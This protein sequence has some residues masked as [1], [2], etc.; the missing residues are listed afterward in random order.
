MSLETWKDEFYPVEALAVLKK[1]AVEHSLRK[2]RGLRA[3]NRAKHGVVL[4]ACG[5]VRGD[6]G[7][8]LVIASS[9]CALCMWYS[10]SVGY[11]RRCPIVKCNG[12]GCDGD[13]S[14]YV[15]FLG[16]GDPEPMIAL[17]EKTLAWEKARKK[18]AR[19]KKVPA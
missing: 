14:P 19:A 4:E 6:D 11:C 5:I 13:G 16:R 10:D 7:A 2:W 17:L 12:C 15:E 18:P 1:D 3:A 9:T 8:G